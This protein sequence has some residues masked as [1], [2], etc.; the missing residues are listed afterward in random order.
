MA[1][2]QVV[3]LDDSHVNEKVTEAQ[4]RFY[5]SE[6][7]RRAL[8]VLVTRGEAAY[9]ENLR[10]EQ[11]RDFLSSR[12]LQALRGGWRGYDDPRDSGK[13]LRGPG[14]EALS[15]AYWP[16]CSDTEVPP[17]DLGW[18]DKTFYRGI[19][20]V[21]LFTH[22]RKEE[23]APHVKEV[24]REMIQQAQKVGTGRPSTP[25]AAPPSR[26]GW[27]APGVVRAHHH[28][29]HEAL[30]DGPLQAWWPPVLVVFTR[31][32]FPCGFL[33]VTLRFAKADIRHGVTPPPPPI[34]HWGFV[35]VVGLR[36]PA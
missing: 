16:E 25:A 1:E 28:H 2:S 10:K 22:P 13:V 20:R 31:Q 9:R 14:G 23:N 7:Q 32:G 17:L 26:L 8:E 18:T 36:A 24:V 27:G 21:A 11:L 34:L 33:P 15:L 3:L 19:S 4:A 5:Y 35:A 30:L 29:H 6:E 12:E